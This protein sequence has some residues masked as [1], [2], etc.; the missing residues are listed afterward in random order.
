MLPDAAAPIATASI[1]PAT[2]WSV[3]EARAGVVALR[4]A[5]SDSGV[6][7]ASLMAG[8]QTAP[9]EMPAQTETVPN[10]ISRLMP[11]LSSGLPAEISTAWPEAAYTLPDG[12]VSSIEP[13]APRLAAHLQATAISGG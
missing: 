11:S 5:Q 10:L 1:A 3:A 4:V 6:I 9:A 2:A 13:I 12:I 7:V 8:D